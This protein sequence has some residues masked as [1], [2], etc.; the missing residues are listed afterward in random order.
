[1]T[2]V[3]SKATGLIYLVVWEGNGCVTLMYPKTK[4]RHT[5]SQFTLNKNYR[6]LSK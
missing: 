6:R 4:E 1:M 3:E 2:K 5:I